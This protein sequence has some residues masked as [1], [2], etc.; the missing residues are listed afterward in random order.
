MDFELT[1]EQ[2][3]ICDVIERVAQDQLD[4]AA[5]AAEQNRSTPADIIKL[6]AETGLLWPMPIELGGSGLVDGLAAALGAEAL[7][8]GD[9]AITVD[10]VRRSD[11]AQLLTELGTVAQQSAYLTPLREDATLL[12]GVALYEG[13]GRAPSEYRTRISRAASG[14]WTVSGRKQ[15][16][17]LGTNA[18]FLLVVGRDDDGALR[19]AI[20]E[21]SD[22]GITVEDD[23]LLI[24]LAAAPSANI[25]FCCE[26]DEDRILGGPGAD[27]GGLSRGL[28]RIR[29]T[30]AFIA[31]GLARRAVGY[32][33]AYAAERPVF[34]KTISAFQGPA[35]LLA[36]AD[37]QIR[38]AKLDAINAAVAIDAADV[39]SL[40]RQITQVVNYACGVANKAA[41]DS[42]QVLGGHGFITDHPVERWYRA[43]GGLS[44]LD[45]DPTC[46]AFSP[47]L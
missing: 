29:L 4:P 14:R 3:Q 44:A 10:L 1:D 24:G 22:P 17:P 39:R 40:E 35:F 36:D 6:V 28:S 34:G 13:Y 16:V 12:V 37:V 2:R 41:R 30:T 38:A 46:S 47:A 11:F 26:V 23:A 20:V 5:R 32:A 42:L 33:S 8:G 43:A 15:A 19:A 31:L 25:A 45:F 9:P 18:R 7:A 27:S 21:G